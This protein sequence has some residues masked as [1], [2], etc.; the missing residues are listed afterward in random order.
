MER[1]RLPDDLDEDFEEFQKEASNP[2]ATIGKR[3][4]WGEAAEPAPVQVTVDHDRLFPSLL[5]GNIV[6]RDFDGSETKEVE[7]AAVGQRTGFPKAVH[8]SNTQF[9]RF[10]NK[11]PPPAAAAVGSAMAPHRPDPLLAPSASA[12]EMR[13]SIK[14]SGALDPITIEAVLKANKA[15]SATDPKAPAPPSLDLESE[16]LLW[17]QVSADPALMDSTSKQ[18]R[19]DFNGDIIAK[20]KE[21]FSGLYHHGDDPEKAGY[22]VPELAH[23]AKSTVPSQRSVSLT[24]LARIA[25]KMVLGDYL[26]SQHDI[27]ESISSANVLVIARVGLD[28]TH[29]TVLDSSLQFIAGYLGL[30]SGQSE[31][32]DRVFDTKM[33][34]RLIALETASLRVFDETIPEY[35]SDV[36]DTKS[37]GFIMNRIKNDPVAGLVL[38]NLI[39]R[40]RWL[41]QRPSST[42]LQKLKIV[43][44]LSCIA[45]HS[46]ASSE[47]VLECEGLIE[48]LSSAMLDGAWPSL[49][50]QPHRGALVANVL[51][52]FRFLCQSSR[53]ACEAMARFN[54]FEAALKF[55]SV[56]SSATD[57]S[58]TASAAASVQVLRLLDVAFAYGVGSSIL[59]QYRTLLIEY[60][61]HYHQIA[62]SAL[63]SKAARQVAAACLG[64]MSKTLC[65]A[66][67][68]F[69]TQLDPGGGN[70]AFFPFAVLFAETLLKVCSSGQSQTD[71]ACYSA[72]SSFANFLLCYTSLAY[73]YQADVSPATTKLI[74]TSLSCCEQAVKGKDLLE[75]WTMSRGS[76]GHAREGGIGLRQRDRIQ[77]AG[78]LVELSER[79]GLAAAFLNVLAFQCKRAFIS[80]KTALALFDDSGF[81]SLAPKVEQLQ[82]SGSFWSDWISFFSQG[83]TTYAN[84]LL[85]FL[86]TAGCVHCGPPLPL[87]LS[88]R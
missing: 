17:T 37:L 42:L 76:P 26:D 86:Q 9:G 12:A 66:L 69:R 49:L 60:C 65:S 85:S 74:R 46:P 29:E 47:D 5:L 18:L 4:Q 52:L 30:R 72:Q 61:H 16:K 6:E 79:L 44:I 23:L 87:A 62:A 57:D 75:G 59:D 88:G 31:L 43:H 27:E 83:I 24:T 10:R 56:P 58:F 48:A 55:L 63:A 81:G 50:S 39:P 70:D 51:R 71:P 22:T 8:R 28:A 25:E 19:F 45:V 67:T 68:V 3:S 13:K 41:F 38:S 11:K 36:E 77:L 20:E 78:E 35:R 15:N 53:K 1:P 84:A 14:A 21:S 34:V 54:L 7:W 32:L 40:L 33:G 2:V 64:A 80:K 82:Q 73:A